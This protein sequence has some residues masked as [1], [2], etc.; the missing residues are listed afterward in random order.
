MSGGEWEVDLKLFITTTEEQFNALNARLDDLQSTPKYKS[1][2]SRNNDEEEEDENLDGRN[3]ENEKRRKCE[4]RC[5]N[6]LGSMN[7]DDYYKEMEI[8][9]IRANVEE[10]REATMARF[11][12]GLKKEIADMV[13][14]QHYMEIEELNKAIQMER[15]LKCQGVEYIASQ[16][17]NKR[18]MIM[19]DNGE[20]ESESSSDDEMSPL[21]DCSDMEVVELV[22]GV[23][24]VTR[25]A[26]S[27]QPKEDGDVEQREHIF[28]SRCLV[29]GKV[30]SIILDGG[31]CTNVANT[32]LVE[33]INLQTA[34]H[35]RPYK[36]QWLSNIGE[37]KVDKQV[38]VLFAIGKY[39]DEVLCY[40][41]PMEVEHILLSY[42]WQF[43]R[44]VT[45][46]G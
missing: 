14:L 27:I 26:L 10:D 7:V 2:T 39:K 11:I 33:K 38:L 28:H 24:L 17:P 43:D 3:N 30:C 4:P 32:I 12:G 16:Y 45:H 18:D 37:V 15:Q 34:K 8:V 6:Y 19:M 1:P 9:M 13:E 36:L 29:R 40:V 21:E 41:V 5:H 42:P 35:L 22:N 25:R 31:S 20:V 23:V 46:N 44:K